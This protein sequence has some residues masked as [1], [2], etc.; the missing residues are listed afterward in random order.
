MITCIH[1]IVPSWLTDI[2][3]IH[4]KTIISFAWF[5][6]PYL[7]STLNKLLH[8]LA[9]QIDVSVEC[10]LLISRLQQMPMFGTAHLRQRDRLY[11]LDIEEDY[12]LES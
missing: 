4:D 7:P 3:R 11:N 2:P 10:S 8:V 5:R 6:L 9:V 1:A 12:S